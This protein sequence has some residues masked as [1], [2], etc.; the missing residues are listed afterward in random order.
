MLILLLSICIHPQVKKEG[1]RDL[2]GA[3][4]QARRTDSGDI[5]HKTIRYDNPRLP[6]GY[7]MNWKRG[8]AA[9]AEK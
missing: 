4:M 2:T 9:E 1:E 8:D 3:C 6:T 7:W 5:H